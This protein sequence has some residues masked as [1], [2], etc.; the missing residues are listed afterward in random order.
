MPRVLIYCCLLCDLLL[1]K[2][3]QHAYR[4][5][6]GAPAASF[7]GLSE[8]TNACYACDVQNVVLDP[9][10]NKTGLVFGFVRVLG[11]SITFAGAVVGGNTHLQ[12]VRKNLRVRLGDL[13]TVSACGDVPYGKRV[14]V[15]PVDDTIEG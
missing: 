6:I 11:S 14:H 1:S 2:T 12:V 5:E 8:N 4:C 13:I 10:D 15:L 9:S 7:G 3:K